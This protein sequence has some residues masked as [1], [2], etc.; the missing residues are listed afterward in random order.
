MASL[1]RS[2]APPIPHYGL[3][4]MAFPRYSS[5]LLLLAALTAAARASGALQ[6]APD[7]GGI[8]LPAG[9][10]A[11]VVADGLSG[12]RGLAV[13]PNGDVYGKVRGRGVVAL[14][15]ND[16]DGVADVVET[17]PGTAE[18]GSGM[19]VQPGF[20]YFSSDDTIFRLARAPGELVPTGTPE[21]VVADLPDGKQH[22]AKM[23]TFDAAGNLF[24]EV[25]S[26]SNALGK[27]DRARGAIGESAKEVE[28]F[29]STHGGIWKFELKGATLPL[30]QANGVHWS[31][32]H[33]HILALAWNPVSRELFAA[34]NGRDVLD[35]VNPEVFNQAYNAEHVAEEFHVLRQGANLGWPYTFFDPIAGKRLFS[36]EYGG[37]GQKAP[38]AGVFQAPLIAF[39]AH[40]APMQMAYAAGTQFPAQYR[41]GFFLAFHGSWN[42]PSQKGYNV[43]YIPCDAQGMPTGQWEIF[44]NDFMGKDEIK[45]PRDATYRPMGL[46]IGP[47]GS[48]YIGS[49]QG[50][51]IWRVYYAGE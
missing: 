15:D 30:T 27:P 9:F 26:P 17:V 35:V 37:D 25:G 36:P 6:P 34:Q 31:T 50:G 42:R 21:V 2:C 47:D 19:G 44:A 4:S 5:V 41:G 32:G 13:A 51:R 48:L 14:R 12:L 3:G 40:W 46:A 8:T 10:K 16:G 11:V 39:P 23:F 33:R 45:S 29:L 24:A 38:P 1:R 20:L 43:V 22:N 18:A 28:A 49:D 7:N